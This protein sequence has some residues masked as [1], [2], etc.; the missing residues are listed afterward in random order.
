M[1]KFGHIATTKVSGETTADYKFYEFD[2]DG[3]IP[4]LRVAPATRSNKAYQAGLMKATEGDQQRLARGKIP[5]G[6]ID[7]LREKQVILYSKHIV[8]GWENVLDQDKNPVPFSEADCLDF[9]Q[10]IPAQSF[11]QLITFCENE[12]NFRSYDPK[13][14]AK[15]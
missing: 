8:R 9:L 7:T 14:I 6:Y 11:D 15:N 1:S 5:A 2:V 3:A 13:E 10:A 4:T 12:G